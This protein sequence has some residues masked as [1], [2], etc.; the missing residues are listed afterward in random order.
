MACK[1]PAEHHQQEQIEAL[2]VTVLV[3]KVENAFTLL[4]TPTYIS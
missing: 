1:V 4:V 3:A 2:A